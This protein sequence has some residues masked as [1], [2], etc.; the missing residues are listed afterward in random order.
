MDNEA[1]ELLREIR[2]LQKE[3]LQLIRANIKEAEEVNRVALENQTKWNQ[4]T[5][6]SSKL[7]IIMVIVI[8][9]SCPRNAEEGPVRTLQAC[10]RLF[11]SFCLH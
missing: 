8:R 7:M 6:H 3:H 11:S 4:Q 2:D 10:Q 9:L 5:K 1:K